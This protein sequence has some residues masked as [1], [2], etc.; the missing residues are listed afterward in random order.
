[1][2]GLATATIWIVVGVTRGEMLALA[3]G[4]VGV[5]VFIPWTLGYY[6]GDTLGAPAVA[7][8]SG[9]LLLV[10]VALLVRRERSGIRRGPRGRHFHRM[11]HP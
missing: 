5:F 2:L 8:A 4:V 1:L 10:A 11:A 3:P 9:A 7:M 6:F